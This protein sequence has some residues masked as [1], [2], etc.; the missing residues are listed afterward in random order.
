MDDI[1]WEIMRQEDEAQSQ[2]DEEM[3]LQQA[4]AIGVLIYAGAEESRR[5]QSEQRLAHRTYLT[6]PELPPEP[7][8]DSAWLRLYHSQSDRAFITTMGF[9]VQAF[10]WILQAGFNKLWNL[11]P[12]PCTDVTDNA[13]PRA[14]RRS[15]DAAGA[16]GLVL[17][18][19][20]STMTEISLQQIFA[21]VPATSSRY[22]NFGLEI[23]L[24]T[25]LNIEEAGIHWP[26]GEEFEELTNL[27]LVRHPLLS[28]AFGTMDGLNLAVQVSKYQEM[29]N[30]T[31]NGWLHSHFVSCV[32]AF[33][34]HGK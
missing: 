22:I 9:N 16:L 33:A 11:L 29:E 25:L 20:S 24:K 10:D 17:H 18:F 27:V 8:H 14:Y 12:I 31:F 23:L 1:E 4:V 34:S 19:L 3:R 21:L 30:A 5:L 13:V 32:L 26:E 7:C 6:R 15:L 28:G 2:E